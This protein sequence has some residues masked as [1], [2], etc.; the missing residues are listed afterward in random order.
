[1]QANKD[2][3]PGQVDHMVDYVAGQL[4]P[5][6]ALAALRQ[7][8]VTITRK[9]LLKKVSDGGIARR[10]TEEKKQVEKYENARKIGKATILDAISA[11]SLGHDNPDVVL[12]TQQWKSVG[13]TLL[14]GVTYNDIFA[15]EAAIIEL[16]KEMMDAL[17]RV[18][19]LGRKRPAMEMQQ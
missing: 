10:S 11:A 2:T 15:A 13:E 19:R 5:S 14:L 9:E 8:G 16:A 7:G 18:R 6:V 4:A 17:A 1:M 3:W 12:L